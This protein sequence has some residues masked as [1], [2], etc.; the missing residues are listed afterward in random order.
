VF[1]FPDELADLIQFDQHTLAVT[2]RE[3]KHREFKQGF[4]ANDLS[5]YTK[6]LAAFGNADG[7]HIL[8]GI[9]DKPR[10]IVGTPEIPD[11]A[12]WSDRLREDFDPEISIMTKVYSVGALQVYAVATNPNTHRPV[13]CKKGRSK[14]IIGRDGTGRDVEVIR[15]GAIYYRYSGQTRTIGYSEL[16]ALLAER[17]ARRVKSFMETL[18]IIQKVGVDKAGILTMSEEASTI[19][20]T[21]ETAKGL[22]LI[23]KG[24]LVEE[25]GAPAYVVMGNVDIKSAV[26]A[27]LD[28]ADKNLPTE[29]AA[30]IRP[31]VH[32]VYDR[33]T[34]ITAGQVSKV[35]KHLALSNDNIHVVEERK[36]RRKFI[37]RAGIKAVEDFIQRDPRPA[38]K[39]FGSRS[40]LARYDARTAVKPNDGKTVPASGEQ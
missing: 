24:R 7:G 22:S 31:L 20:M 28:E 15:E 9:S 2:A 5:D 32:K 27:S 35:L 40:A 1:Q 37:T 39:S 10:Q 34:K 13:V 21:P 25:P 18:N 33:Q 3:S 19:V 29:A 8:F 30:R 4:L 36:F 23:D 38:L 6:T 26:H 17:E 12:R 11:E 16:M 14:R